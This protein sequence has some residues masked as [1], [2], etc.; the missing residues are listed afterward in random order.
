MESNPEQCR[1]GG[2][3]AF[4]GIV[5]VCLILVGLPQDRC[6]SG[7]LLVSAKPAI[8]TGYNAL[9]PLDALLALLA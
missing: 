3:E 1:P 8:D 6:G 4:R 2:N 5:C 9:L 7:V